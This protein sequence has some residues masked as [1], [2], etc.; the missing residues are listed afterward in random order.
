MATIRGLRILTVAAQ[1]LSSTLVP[2]EVI[3][4]LT[5]AA[6][7]LCSAPGERPRRAVLMLIE[8]DVMAIRGLVDPTHEATYPSPYVPLADNPYARQVLATGETL[9]TGFEPGDFGPSSSEVIRLAAVR[10]AAMVPMR[11]DGAVFAILAVSGRQELLISADML[12]HL[13]TLAAIGALAYSNADLHQQ[14]TADLRTDPLTSLA[15][16]RAL[17]QRFAELPRCPFAMLA[18]DVD[19][20]K[21][22]NDTHG[23]EAGDR[24]LREVAVAMAAQVR[25]GDLLVR[26]GG[27]EFVALLVNCD[28][29]GAGEASDRLVAAVGA[30]VL[31][32]GRASISVG[33]AAGAPGT[34]PHEVLSQAD[35]ALYREKTSR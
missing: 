20:L 7:E 11:R 25:P 33:R 18:I 15:N 1:T 8:G 6:S 32:W 29:R 3:T 5:R 34:S 35:A 17:E 19:L 27:D 21:T 4:G 16:R 12:S 28:E 10:N 9:V 13:E 30:V 22:V 31:P 2:D 24:L 23:H 14:A 26:S